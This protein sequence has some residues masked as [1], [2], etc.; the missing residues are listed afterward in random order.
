MDDI[1][2]YA[3]FGEVR[4][5]ALPTNITDR[6]FTGHKH[7]AEIGLIYMN[8]RFYDPNT[9]RMLTPD[10]IVPDPTNPQSLNR[11]SYTRNNPINRIDPTGHIDCNILG[12]EECNPENPEQ[13]IDSSSFPSLPPLPAAVDIINEWHRLGIINDP[14]RTDILRVPIMSNDML[15]GWTYVMPVGSQQS[16]VSENSI[17]YQFGRGLAQLGIGLDMLELMLT[18]SPDPGAG[19]AL[20]F[21]DAG[22]TYA[23]GLLTGDNYGLY[24]HPDLPQMVAVNQDLLVNAGEAIIGGTAPY[25]F[26]AL[27]AASTVE[28]GPAG[29]AIGGG[30]GFM[31]GKMTD[32]V[33][34]T[35]SAL[36]DGGRYNG[37]IYNHLMIGGSQEGIVII[38]WPSGS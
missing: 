16:Y 24:Q 6:G 2:R 17:Q 21:V 29:M 3:P 28:T 33:T 23:S 38:W 4:G 9:N 8:A 7:N 10:S 34:S 12:T 35:A 20:G 36:Y 14:S 22:V 18:G 37:S 19:G 11:Y 13:Y 15:L 31:L 25:L 30:T 32:A 26:A 1:V 5:G 27:G